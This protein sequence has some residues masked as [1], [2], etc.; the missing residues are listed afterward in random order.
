[1]YQ[2]AQAREQEEETEVGTLTSGTERRVFGGRPSWFPA[3]FYS[4]G[5]NAGS[6]SVD[7]RLN[8]LLKRVAAFKVLFIRAKLL[9]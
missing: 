4:I 8:R 7:L 3:S 5:E 6:T 1:M 9:K 2:L